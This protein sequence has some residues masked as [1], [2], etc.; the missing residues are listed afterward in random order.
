MDRRVNMIT[1]E[2]DSPDQIECSGFLQMVGGRASSNKSEFMVDS[3]AT[4]HMTNSRQL[5]AGFTKLDSSIKLKIAKGG[6]YITATMRGDLQLI[7]RD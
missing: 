4:E 3:G 5:A 2:S 1:T 6:E 7:R